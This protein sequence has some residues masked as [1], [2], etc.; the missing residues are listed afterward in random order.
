MKKILV[1]IMS[2]TLLLISCGQD[3]KD[4]SDTLVN[5]NNDTS[6]TESSSEDRQ[7]YEVKSTPQ[8]S[9]DT[10]NVIEDWWYN[11]SYENDQFRRVDSEPLSTF[12]TDVD[13]GSYTYI[14]HY[15]LDDLMPPSEIVRIEEMINYFDYDTPV[16]EIE[17]IAISSELGIC[18]WNEDHVLAMIQL[19]AREL[20]VD[21]LPTSNLVFLLD[22]SGS[23]N[24]KDK[25]P[26]LKKGFKM[27]S[28]QLRPED[29]VSIVVY[30][31]ASG[32]VLDGA[33][34]D[35]IHVIN[36]AIERLEAGGSTAGSVGIEKAYQ[37]AEKYFVPHGNNR[38]ILATDGDF[39]VGITSDDDLIE[40][41]EEKR[42]SGI[43]LS[44]LGF[45]SDNIKD[46]KLEQ[47]ADHG[48]GHYAYIDSVLEAKKVLV[49]E[50]YSTVYTL[51]KDAKI[52]V[53]FNPA[54]VAEYKLIGYD[55]RQ[56]ENR[57]FQDDTKDAG[58]IGIG[59]TV[60]VFYEI[61][62]ETLQLKY[63]NPI[64]EWFEIRLRYKKPN[65]QVSSEIKV[66]VPYNLPSRNTDDFKFAATVAEFGLRLK[67]RRYDFDQLITQAK[68]SKGDDD[69]G[70]RAEFIKLLEIA[71][72]L[73]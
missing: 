10:A 30:A 32:V 7:D 65:S 68:A 60:T 44:V 59:H 61:V 73:K 31:G 18:P 14:R 67:D 9:L 29:R 5:V 4:V 2:L 38:V 63:Q 6:V 52:Q 22:V 53:E 11:E 21:V 37:L 19:Q 71:N 39:N 26:L 66:G 8:E 33:Y 49:D 41:I 23:M 13:T 12:S 45:G 69:Q 1:L 15:L 16:P 58:E 36:D 51:A 56:L 42:E 40:L 47:I 62:P 64:N 55:N 34:G 24:Q 27:L 46:G 20:E 54:Y 35:E 48:N 28:D 50:M 43:Y 70:Y 17:P 3:N 57:D 25:L 72:T